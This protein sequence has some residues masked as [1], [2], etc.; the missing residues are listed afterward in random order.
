MMVAAIFSIVISVDTLNIKSLG[1]FNQR[2][3]ISKRSPSLVLISVV[4]MFISSS[5][6][7]SI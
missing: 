2:F 3:V 7:V 5:L 1:F 6:P 4:S